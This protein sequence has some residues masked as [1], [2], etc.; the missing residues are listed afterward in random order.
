[1]R[2]STPALFDW[3]TQRRRRKLLAQPFPGA[4]REILR[5]N[6]PYANGFLDEERRRFEDIVRVLVT[7]KHFEGC[8]GFEITD[9]VRLTIAG[10][11]AIPVVNLEEAY[12]PA[13]RS[14]LV[15]PESFRVTDTDVGD[16][17]VWTEE[18]ETRAGESWDL[19]VIV[20]AWTE[21]VRSYKKLADGYN[22]VL[23][24][25]AHQLDTAEW[26]SEG[27]PVLD[28]SELA[29]RWAEVLSAEFERHSSGRRGI[30]DPYGAL[31][32][33]EFFAVAIETFFE[34]PQAMKRFHSDLYETLRAYLKQ[35]SAEIW[36]RAKRFDSK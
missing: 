6:V 9:E 10:H 16:D 27:L 25:F 5:Q 31:D 23:H 1:M 30:L 4:W 34:K 29:E 33:A 18:A 21:V 17:G 19:G 7:E 28:D 26:S 8:D 14:I 3:F 22:V 13:L 20:L 11:A 15:Y 32:P 24:E 2:G 12:Y 35:D 36:E